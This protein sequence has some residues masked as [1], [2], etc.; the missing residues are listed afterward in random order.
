MT[1][2][3]GNGPPMVVDRTCFIASILCY[4]GVNNKWRAKN[5]AI[6]L[7]HR[8]LVRIDGRCG[9]SAGRTRSEESNEHGDASGLR[10]GGALS[11]VSCLRSDR[12]RL[13]TGEM[14]HTPG[15]RRWMVFYRRHDPM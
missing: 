8:R 6:F 15:L 4:I 1:Q 13:G 9:R 2:F 10:G 5:G 14:A 11:D 12:D 3:P 7:R